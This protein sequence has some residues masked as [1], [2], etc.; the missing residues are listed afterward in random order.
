MQ[1]TIRE[2]SSYLGVNEATMTRWIEQRGLPAH[3]ASERW[4]VN[5]IELWEWAVEHGVPASRAHPAPAS[6]IAGVAPCWLWGAGWT[7]VRKRS[8]SWYCFASSSK[9]RTAW[10]IVSRYAAGAP[11]Q[12]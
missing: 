2:A 11:S 9:F 12:S 3:R 10:G 8:R 1:L 7:A 6:I 4:Y 5:P